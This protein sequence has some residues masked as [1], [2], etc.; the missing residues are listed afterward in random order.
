MRNKLPDAVI[1][2]LLLNLPEPRRTVIVIV[3]LGYDT[4]NLSPISGLIW[5]MP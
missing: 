5:R 3:R 4:A 2:C 1:R